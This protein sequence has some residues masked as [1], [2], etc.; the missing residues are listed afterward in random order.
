MF[1]RQP[2][3]STVEQLVELGDQGVSGHRGVFFFFRFRALRRASPC[4]AERGLMSGAVSFNFHSQSPQS[5]R[6][7]AR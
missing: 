6:L 7:L 1:G 3:H 4:V 2:G 5:K